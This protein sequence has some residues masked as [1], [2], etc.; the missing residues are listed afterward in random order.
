VDAKTLGDR[1]QELRVLK[2]QPGWRVLVELFKEHR[3][4]EERRLARQLLRAG[5]EI[6]QRDVDFTRGFLAGAKWLL[7][8]PDR[9]QRDFDTAVRQGRFEREGDSA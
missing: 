9:I 4:S 2:N 6:S 1:A 8:N 7:D 3:D 5:A